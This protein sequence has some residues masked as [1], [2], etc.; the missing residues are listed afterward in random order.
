MST[1]PVRVSGQWLALRE[2][3]DARARSPELVQAVRR[4]LPADRPAVIYDLGCGTGAM[5]R[6]L[7]P[8]LAG[9]QHWVMYDRDAEL[10]ARAIADP[11]RLDA[12]RRK[13]T[14]EARQ[15][16]IS[17]LEPSDLVDASLVT[18]SALLDIMT[19]DELDRFVTICAA[20]GT[21]VL[22]CLSVTGRVEL[23]PAD[24]L[25]QHIS[26]AFN[27]HQR[28]TTADGHRHGPDAVAAAVEAFRALGAHVVVR[29]SPWR[30]DTGNGDAALAAA[31]LAGW[32]GAACTQRP[33]L[34][35]AATPYVER[36]LQAAESGRLRI[37]VHHED[38]L[39]TSR[40]PPSRSTGRPTGL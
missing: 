9:P 34:T 3:A 31:W 14:V 16:D 6:W 40:P 33:E 35:D 11:P 7:A 38:L 29:P 37:T 24:P 4:C 32:I 18:A 19:T 1:Q 21:P 2:S 15:R 8:Q 20:A 25:D 22:I 26:E 17:R 39:A 5:G 13:V 36:R 28:R 27:A 23:A 12:D 10:L 30:L